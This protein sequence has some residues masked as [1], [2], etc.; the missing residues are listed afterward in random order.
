MP[1]LLDSPALDLAQAVERLRELQARGRHLIALALA[2]AIA[3]AALAAAGHGRT[4]V[5]LVIG[6]AGALGL[7][8]LCR[9]DRRRL[10]VALVAQGDAWA[11]EGVRELAERLR[12]PQE[13]RRLSQGLRAAAEAGSPGAQLSMMVDPARA[14]DVGDRL[15][16]LAERCGDPVLKV[17]AQAAAICRRLLCDPQH[18]PL[19]NPHVPEGDLRRVLELLERELT[20]RP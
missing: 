20:A 15:N 6:A 10:L 8:G 2:L 17:N 14:H 5:P 12:G 16:A 18:S 13:R 3:G 9:T 11:L 1:G 19:Y 7:A 4:G